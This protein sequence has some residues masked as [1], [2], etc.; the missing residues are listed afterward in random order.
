MLLHDSR[1]DTRTAPDGAL[2]LLD[3]QDRSRWNHT[4]IT[5]GAELVERALER[6]RVGPYVLQAA[7]AAIHAQAR[8]PGDTDWN[9]IVGLYDVLLRVTPSPV[10]E[11]NRAAAIAMRDGPGA[12]LDLIDALLA[13]GDLADYPLAHSARGELLRRLHRTAEA[14]EAYRAALDRATQ[15][16]QRRLLEA[17]LSGLGTPD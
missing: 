11:L 14:K 12:G 6:R 5:E 8:R 1:R 4:Q 3:D 2:V 9:E 15:E 16:P 17:R 13:R 10:V 7:I